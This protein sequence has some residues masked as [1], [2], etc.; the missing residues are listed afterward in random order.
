MPVLCE[1]NWRTNDTLVLMPGYAKTI[2]VQTAHIRRR[3]AVGEAGDDAYLG[4]LPG[5][6]WEIGK[7]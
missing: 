1:N 2:G 4:Y 6:R 7:N 3:K 5:G